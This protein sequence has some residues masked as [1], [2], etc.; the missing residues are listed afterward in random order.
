VVA[1]ALLAAF[2]FGD[3][4]DAMLAGASQPAAASERVLRVGQIYIDGADD[5]ATS[6]I[7][8][9]LEFQTGDRIPYSR[10]RDAER[11]L[12]RLG[13]FVVDKATGVRPDI[14]ELPDGNVTNLR[15]TVRLRT[16]P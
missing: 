7:L 8:N 6:A 15:I 16:R 2:A 12:N 10:R 11:R 13:L 3:A 1:V 14:A 4:Q 9:E 5:M